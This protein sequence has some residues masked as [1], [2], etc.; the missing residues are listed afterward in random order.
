MTRRPPSARKRSTIGGAGYVSPGRLAEAR[1]VHLEGHPRLHERAQQRLVDVRP[2]RERRRRDMAGEV[3]LHVVEVADG[4]EELAPDGSLDLGE[5]RPDDRVERSPG[6][7]ARHPAGQVRGIRPNVDRADG[8]VVGVVRQVLANLGL[9]VRLVADLDAEPHPKPAIRPARGRIA[10]LPLAGGERRVRVGRIP[11]VEV[12]VVGDR[13]LRD[14]PFDRCR[15]VRVDRHVAVGR[16]VRVEVCVQREIAVRLRPRRGQ[17][18]H[19]AISPSSRPTRPNAS[20]QVSSSSSEWAAVTM[21]RR[22]AP[23]RATVG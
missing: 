18:G 1:R 2:G 4:V 16:Q 3:L 6:D 10:H 22:R 11:R 12:Q 21:V 23:S 5:V 13:D 14:P 8:V 7:P 15:A 9:A 17:R 20:R 19:P